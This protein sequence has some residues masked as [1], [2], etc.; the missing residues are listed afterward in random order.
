[1]IESIEDMLVRQECEVL[2]AY[3]DSKGYLTIGVGQLIDPKVGGKISQAASRFM[4]HEAI[5]DSVHF[6]KSYPWYEELNNPMK[7]AMISMMYTLGPSRFACFKN[8]IQA[9]KD[10]DYERASNE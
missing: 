9:L 3:A 2:H 4:L 6:L 10:R 1:M 5:Q 8:M 7:T